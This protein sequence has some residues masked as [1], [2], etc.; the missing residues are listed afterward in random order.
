M[1]AREG[2]PALS[3]QSD[4]IDIQR[5]AFGLLRAHGVKAESECAQMITRWEERGD[6]QAAEL[7]RA[8][9]EVVRKNQPTK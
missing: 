2:R 8:V 3:E 6:A 4:N 5:A 1:N 9:L 7:W